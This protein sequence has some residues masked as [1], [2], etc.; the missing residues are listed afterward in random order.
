MSHQQYLNVLHLCRH[1]EHL[2]E[3]AYAVS[4]HIDMQDVTFSITPQ[5]RLEINSAADVKALCDAQVFPL[6]GRAKLQKLYQ[7]DG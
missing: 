2:A 3:A 5:N 4:F 7:V 1:L 6:Q